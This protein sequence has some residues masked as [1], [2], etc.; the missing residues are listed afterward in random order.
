MDG[1]A[2]AF[3]LAKSGLWEVEADFCRIATRRASSSDIESQEE[4]CNTRLL[5]FGSLSE[6]KTDTP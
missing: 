5:E 2:D 1:A 6:V 4:Q 3:F